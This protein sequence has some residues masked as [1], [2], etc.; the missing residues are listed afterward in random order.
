MKK[1]R[2]EKTQINTIR[3]EKGDIATNTNEN[4]WRVL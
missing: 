4:H 1:H 3:D 2:R